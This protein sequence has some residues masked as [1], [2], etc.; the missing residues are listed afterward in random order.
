MPY[1]IPNTTSTDAYQTFGNGLYTGGWIQVMQQTGT[2]S[3]GG[4][5]AYCT[6]KPHGPQSPISDG[7]VTQLTPG[8][9]PLQG[10]KNNPIVSV[11]FKSA[12]PGQPCQVFGVLYEENASGFGSG[13]SLSGTIS[14][15]G[16]V[17]VPTGATMNTGTV[18]AFAGTTAPTG[19][20]FCDGSTYDGTQSTYLALWNVIGTTYGG[21]G[22]SAFK[23]PDLQGRIIVAKGTN[24]SVNALGLN[25][26]V[27]LANRRPQHRHTPHSHYL[28]ISSNIATA[29]GGQ[30]TIGPGGTTTSN[31]VDGGSGV[32]TDSLDSPA[33]MVLNYIIYL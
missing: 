16:T 9:Y 31:A 7:E 4:V 20:L 15:T 19:A 3:T 21:S 33:Y 32:S 22:Q 12:V 2:T 18:T 11:S 1:S 10:G 14:S 30:G 23:V 6:T 27:S 29:G 5:F 24:A 26:G 13:T 17:I 28:L 8:W 25:D